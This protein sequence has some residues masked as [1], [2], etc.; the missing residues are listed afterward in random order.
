MKPL[1]LTMTAFGPFAGRESID[2]TLLGG[3][4]IFLITG[5]T[6]SGKTTIF[7]AIT[8]ALYGEA[9]GSGR[10]PENFRSDC[11]APDAL[12]SVELTFSLK[13]QIHRIYRQPTQLRLGK[14]GSPVVTQ[15]K[16]E[17]YTDGEPPVTGVNSVDKAVS[18]LLGLDVEQFKKIVMLAQGDF[19]PGCW[20]PTAGKSRRSSAAF[21]EQ[22]SF[23]RITRA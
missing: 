2:F 9:S 7:D 4:G 12:C 11:A 15:A 1:Q 3:Q 20:K 18:Q 19:S 22:L 5:P 21:S 14:R 10:Q 23:D 13:G 17:L 6:G 16:A 8:F